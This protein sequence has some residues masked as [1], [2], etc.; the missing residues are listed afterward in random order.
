MLKQ[1]TTNLIKFK[2]VFLFLSIPN[3]I[4]FVDLKNLIK[5]VEEKLLLF[6]DRKM[7][8]T[9]KRWFIKYHYGEDSP[10]GEKTQKN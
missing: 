2:V 10:R 8:F 4:K 9:V 7:G 5:K 3:S 6:S 1:N